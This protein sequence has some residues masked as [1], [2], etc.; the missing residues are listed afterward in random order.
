MELIKKI[1]DKPIKTVAEPNHRNLQLIYTP[2]LDKGMKDF[3][4]LISTLYPLNGQT[5]F[6]THPVDEMILILS[7]RG[8]AIIE[9]EHYELEPGM[10]IYA[11]AGV[12]HQCKNYAAESMKMA[13]Y[14]ISSLPDEVI[15]NLKG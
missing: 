1:W 3:T 6:H 8:E 5:D 9:E 4:F 15:E 7:G 14:Y 11:P 2:Q 10:V 12:Q 13:C